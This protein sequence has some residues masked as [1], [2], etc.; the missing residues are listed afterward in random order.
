MIDAAWLFPVAIVAAIVTFVGASFAYARHQ[1]GR[2]QR[3][4]RLERYLRITCDK[5]GAWPSYT[6]VDIEAALKMT[7]AEVVDAALRSRHIAREI[8]PAMFGAPARLLL[9][10]DDRQSNPTRTP[11][12]SRYFQTEP[13]P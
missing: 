7:E 2:S 8:R 5:T 13:L 4:K 3:R 9:K 6:V 12:H 1:Y 10:Y 11:P